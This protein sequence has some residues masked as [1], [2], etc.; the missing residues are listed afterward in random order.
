MKVWGRIEGYLCI[1][2]QGDDVRLRI[3]GI[4]LSLLALELFGYCT[5]VVSAIDVVVDNG[6]NSVSMLTHYFICSSWWIFLNGENSRA[7]L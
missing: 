3:K 1:Y 7:R 5:A 6:K 4:L 2:G